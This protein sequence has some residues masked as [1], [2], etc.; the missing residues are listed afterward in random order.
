MKNVTRKDHTK[1]FNAVHYKVI[2][3]T[4]IAHLDT[5]KFLASIQTK[6][7]LTKYLSEKP[8]K[9]DCVVIHHKCLITNIPDLDPSLRN[10]SHEEA[11]TRIVINA[12]DVSK[13]DPFTDLVIS[14]SDTD[15]LLILIHYYEQLSSSIVF[16]TTVHSH[17]VGE[18]Y[19]NLSTS[20]RHALLGFH[21]FTGCDQTGKFSGFGKPSCWTM[22]MNSS[23]KV[24]DAF[25]ELGLPDDP[26]NSFL[27]A[28][29]HFMVQ[30]YCKNKIPPAVT[31]LPE[32]RWYMF[33]KR[34]TESTSLPPTMESLGQK[35]LLSHYTT[36]VWKKSPI[37][38]QDLPD[39]EDYGWKW[40]SSPSWHIAVTTLL[41]PAP[42]S[43]IHLIV[44]GY[45]AGYKTQRYKCKKKGMKCSEKCK[46][47]DCENLEHEDLD[48]SVKMH[49]WKKRTLNRLNKD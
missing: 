28:L 45:K 14:Y 35:V 6:G 21:A 8:V 44:C 11:D 23:K 3:S 31:N 5:K 20:I 49:C 43:I 46:F 30:L 15:V 9:V 41:P 40:P 17:L 29:E 2:D 36:V 10:Y 16:K 27:D 47:K 13:R 18:I 12:I 4:R 19:K 7:E 42:E 37:S 26:N 22:L 1:Q 32:L 24:L 25:Q 34:Q 38:H 39:L 33:S 48:L